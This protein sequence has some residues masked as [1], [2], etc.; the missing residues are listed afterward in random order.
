MRLAARAQQILAE[1]IK[2]DARPSDRCCSPSATQSR[3]ETKRPLGSIKS[4]LWG[5]WLG[6]L[7]AGFMTISSDKNLITRLN[8]VAFCLDTLLSTPFPDISAASWPILVFVALWSEYAIKFA[9][10]RNRYFFVNMRRRFQ[11]EK[12]ISTIF[13][14]LGVICFMFICNLEIRSQIVFGIW[15]SLSIFKLSMRA[16][17]GQGA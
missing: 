14:L 16:L 3:E 7:L 9:V 2:R 12:K 17:C 15:I 11:I 13:V 8:C 10:W 4:G 6:A 5:A 1:R